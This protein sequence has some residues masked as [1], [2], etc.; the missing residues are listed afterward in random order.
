MPKD[1]EFTRKYEDK[2]LH[3]LAESTAIN[4]LFAGGI[5]AAVVVNF[6]SAEQRDAASV[7]AKAALFAVGNVLFTKEVVS[8]EAIKERQP[9]GFAKVLMSIAN[10]VANGH[11]NGVYNPNPVVSG[12]I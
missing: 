3:P 9:N 2:V 6:M 8:P 10:V 1:A 5:G 7:K 12:S 11:I 4:G